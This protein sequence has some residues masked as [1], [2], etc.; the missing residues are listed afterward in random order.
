M[1]DKYKDIWDNNNSDSEEMFQVLERLKLTPKQAARC[2]IRS[3]EKTKEGLNDEASKFLLVFTELYEINL[4]ATC[5]S[6][7]TISANEIIRLALETGYS[8]DMS[9]FP[10]NACKLAI[11]KFF[12]KLG[13]T[14]VFQAR[15]NEERRNGF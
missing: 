15:R 4:K 1:D 13:K 12:S 5:L 7:K 14:M 6:A 8:N 11:R 2:V 10:S 9:H 3:Y